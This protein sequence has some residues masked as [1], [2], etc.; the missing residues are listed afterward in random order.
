MW[1]PKKA[2]LLSSIFE[3]IRTNI[4]LDEKSRKENER[5]DYQVQK[6]GGGAREVNERQTQLHRKGD[7]H[8]RGRRTQE[9]TM[10]HL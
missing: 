9:D 1:V 2:W 8:P 4:T 7:T 6:M 3:G 10:G 5:G